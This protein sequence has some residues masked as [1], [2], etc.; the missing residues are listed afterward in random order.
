V[1][2]RPR[3]LIDVTTVDTTVELFGTR[4]ASP[5]MLAPIGNQKAFH[6]DGELQAARAAKSRKTLQI[7]STSANTSVE[8]L[9]RELG[10]PPWYQL[11]PTQRWEATDHIVRR[12]QAAGC[13]VIALTVDTLAGRKTDTLERFRK[14]DSRKCATCHS[15]EPGGF[16]KR[17]PMFDGINPVGLITGNPAMTWEHVRKLRKIVTVKLLI[18][19]IETRED[20]LLCRECGVDGIIVSNHGGRAEESG[21]GTLECL[22]EV[23]D[24]AAGK[25]P[26]LIDGGFRRGADVFKALALGARA[27]AI[28][29]PYIWGMS[30]FGQ[31]GVERVL[32]LLN[33][34]FQLV[35][36][37]CGTRSLAEIGRSSVIVRS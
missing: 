29:R 24:A 26:V 7:L 4:W 8:D 14:I 20:A 22:P 23:V 33:L 34:E 11:Y 28:G 37:Q 36:K 17:K 31:A 10:Q 9:S 6:P 25:V 27:V 30:A 18:K 2:L 16:Y 5:I 35:M 13:P 3:R 15:T 21:R 12:V 19:G 32:D 1:Q